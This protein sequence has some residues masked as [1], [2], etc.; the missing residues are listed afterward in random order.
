MIAII[1]YISLS[2]REDLGKV[3]QVDSIEKLVTQVSKAKAGDVIV[4]KNGIYNTKCNLMDLD[5]SFPAELNRTKPYGYSL[6]IIDCL[7]GVAQF[8]STSDDDL[9]N[10]ELPDGRGMKL[11]MEF[12]SKYIEN[13]SSWPFKKDIMYWDEWPVRHPSLILYGIKFEDK[14][15]VNLWEGLEPDPKSFEIIRNLPLRHP[16]LWVQ[17]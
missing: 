4:L 12:I 11:G 9:W 7:A 6:F 5:G 14:K 8:A 15:Y 16:L 10:Y 1:A 2:A 13:K 17:S 3:I